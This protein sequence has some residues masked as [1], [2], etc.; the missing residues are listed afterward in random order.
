MDRES[1]WGTEVERITLAYLLNTP[2]VS[3]LTLTGIDTPL[4]KWTYLDDDQ[5]Q[6]SIYLR[7]NGC[8]YQVTACTTDHI[9]CI[10]CTISNIMEFI[11]AACYRRISLL[12]QLTGAAIQMKLLFWLQ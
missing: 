4:V 10:S 3:Y 9:F 11:P 6:M 8:V 1:T 7:N 2:V 5:T 12:Q